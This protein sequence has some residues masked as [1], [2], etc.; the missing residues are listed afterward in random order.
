VRDGPAAGQRDDLV[1]HH[2][3]EPRDERLLARL[4]RHARVLRENPTLF[5]GRDRVG[6]RCR[7]DETA[8]IAPLHGQDHVRGRAGAA[9]SGSPGGERTLARQY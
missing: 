5:R 6:R 3:V 4:E 2:V 8:K 7:A 9:A 1:V